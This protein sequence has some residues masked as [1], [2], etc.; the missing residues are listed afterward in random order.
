M[1]GDMCCVTQS[2]VDILK[3]KD[4]GQNKDYRLLC[5]SFIKGLTKQFPITF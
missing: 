5:K 3:T 2:R 1:K 4:D